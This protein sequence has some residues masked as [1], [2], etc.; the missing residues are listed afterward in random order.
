VGAALVVRL[1]DDAK[2]R[3]S[4]PVRH[5][6]AGPLVLGGGHRPPGRGPQASRA[7]CG[8]HAPRLL[9]WTSLVTLRPN[10]RGR[11]TGVNTVDSG[12]TTP[13]E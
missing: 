12:P 11:T 7:C 8:P 3:L 13:L 6:P 5:G 4:A 9:G 1:V 2:R 10:D